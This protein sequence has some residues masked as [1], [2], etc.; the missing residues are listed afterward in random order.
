MPAGDLRIHGDRDVG[1]LSVYGTFGKL[2]D[3]RLLYCNACKA[4]FFENK[5]TAFI[6][7]K[8]PTEKAFS[9]LEHLTEGNSIRQTGRLTCVHRGTVIRLAHLAGQHTKGSHD[10]RVVF[11]SGPARSSS[12]RSRHRP[13]EAG[14]LRPPRPGR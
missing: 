14:E 12:T 1:N 13:Q 7:S 10:D 8:L 6:R 9:V 11:S 5:G 3:L 4:R 2:Q